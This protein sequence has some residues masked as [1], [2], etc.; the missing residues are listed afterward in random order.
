MFPLNFA[1]NVTQGVSCAN[2]YRVSY[3]GGKINVSITR[4]VLIE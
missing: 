1:E 3:S 4:H 2:T